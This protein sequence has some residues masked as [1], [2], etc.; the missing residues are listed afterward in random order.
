MDKDAA[1]DFLRFHV[2]RK[3]TN[4]SKSFLIV[5]EDLIADGYV[6]P[7]DKHQ[8]IRKKVLDANGETIRDLESYLDKLDIT[9][10]LEK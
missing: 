6:F 10:N 1:K 4:L 5:I 8:R 9:V 7:P 3:I 2:N